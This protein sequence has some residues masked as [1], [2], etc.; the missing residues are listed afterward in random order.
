[1]K[2]TEIIEETFSEIFGKADFYEDMSFLIPQ[3]LN[4]YDVLNNA[5]SV[6]PY[7]TVGVI[8]DSV[9]IVKN[10]TDIMSSKN[11]IKK[12]EDI[13]NN[14]EGNINL[15]EEMKNV[16]TKNENKV[17]TVMVLNFISLIGDILCFVFLTW[18]YGETIKVFAQVL[19]ILIKV[20]DYL[21]Q[22]GR[23]K[24]SKEGGFY[25]KVFNMEKS[26]NNEISKKYEI[27]RLIDNEFLDYM[28]TLD[29]N[30]KNKKLKK[31]D[32]Y[33][34]ILIK[35][36]RNFGVRK[37][38]N[39]Y[40]TRWMKD[41][42]SGA[43]KVGR[44]FEDGSIPFIE[45][46]V[47]VWQFQRFLLMLEFVNEIKKSI[48]DI[49]NRCT[50]KEKLEYIQ[51]NLKS[52]EYVA[53]S[54]ELELVKFL[55][56]RNNKKFEDLTYAIMIFASNI[57]GETGE[58][59]AYFKDTVFEVVGLFVKFSGVVL[60]RGIYL[61]KK[62]YEN[63]KDNKVEDYAETILDIVKIVESLTLDYERFYQHMERLKI[64]LREID[65]KWSNIAREHDTNLRK[66][67]L[68]RALVN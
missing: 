45:S 65:V 18:I 21:K 26:T 23:N 58:F 35:D 30:L 62:M 17:I 16:E 14:F 27:I 66:E 19:R 54:H 64:Y 60:K 6:I 13:K 43:R 22:K 37:E 57:V 68:V 25:A 29:D 3:I 48:N 2:N 38:W 34:K 8:F 4:Y 24:A 7:A 28:D 10:I 20:K 15:I 67:I 12:L 53:V 33:V 51:K 36:V 39:E 1:M 61:N 59:V 11:N 9:K 31:L 40:L 46:V 32:L 44:V 42:V 56:W 52:R 50:L 63:R 41:E 49:S 47:D 5:E 55:V